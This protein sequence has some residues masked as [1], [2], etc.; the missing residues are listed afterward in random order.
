MALNR[1]QALA[2]MVMISKFY[3]SSQK[4]IRGVREH[5][6]AIDR[7]QFN[8]TYRIDRALGESHRAIAEERV[9]A[10]GMLTS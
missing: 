3:V 4:S 10:A 5:F 6:S 1:K 9:H 7:I 8:P 2:G